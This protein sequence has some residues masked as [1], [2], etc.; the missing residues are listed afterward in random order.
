M[1][2]FARLSGETAPIDANNTKHT[3][4]EARNELPS[5]AHCIR[6]RAKPK[7]ADEQD[8]DGTR[9]S[10]ASARNSLHGMMNLG[11]SSTGMNESWNKAQCSHILAN[12]KRYDHSVQS[13]TVTATHFASEVKL[14]GPHARLQRHS[15]VRRCH[16]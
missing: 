13:A 14:G 11:T 4:S 16:R 12:F 5:K 7:H 15:L 9:H 2:P 10:F 8:K 6:T 1:H 3:M